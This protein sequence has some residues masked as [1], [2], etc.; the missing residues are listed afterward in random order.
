MLRMAVGHAKCLDADCAARGAV[1]ACRE[2]LGG[3]KPVGL[4]LFTGVAYDHRTI[5]AVIETVFPGVPL[6]GATTSAVVTDGGGVSEDS[7]LLVAFAGE[8]IAA[9][10]GLVRD[11]SAPGTDPRQQTRAAFEHVRNALPGAVKLC[12]A[13]PDGGRGGAQEFGQ[14]LAAAVGPEGLVLGGLAARQVDDRRPVRQFHGREIY[15]HAA[16]FLLLTGDIPLVFR[17]SR[18]WRPVGGLSRITGVDG[19]VVHRIGEGSALDFYRH[20]LGPHAEPALELPLAIACEKHK[21][22]ILRAPGFYSEEDGSIQFP[23]GV[24]EGAMVQLAEA[25]RPEMLTDI[26]QMAKT[27]AR[28]ATANFTPAGALFFSC[29]TRKDIL[30]TKAG[31][32]AGQ[33]AAALPPGTPVA[34]LY[35][36]GEL[37]AAAPGLPVH[38]QNGSLVAL[39]LGGEKPLARLTP[40]DVPS[41]PTGERE[42]LE[43][44]IRSLSRALSRAN[45]SRQRLEAQKDRSQSLMRVVNREINEAR[46]EI[47]RKNELLRQALA[48]AEEVQRNLLPQ[49]APGLPGFDIA[50]TSLYSDETG[51]DYFDFIHEP[52]EE[53]NRFGVIIGDVTGHGIAAALLMTTAR[54]FLRMRS[55]QPGSLAAVI[56][57]VNKLLCA[58][59]ADSGRFMT[60]FYLAIDIEKKRIHWVRAGHD[61]IILYDAETGLVQD[62]PDKG[63]PPLGIITEAR[64]AENSAEAMKPGQVALLATDGLWEARNAAGEMFGKERVREL[65]GRHHSESAQQ[66]VDAVLAGL[67]DYLGNSQPED[68]VTLVAI[69]VLPE[70]ASK[71]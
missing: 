61:P 40:V 13:F 9:V 6:V 34:G 56:D 24:P 71:A 17:L 35:C 15:L 65:L 64:Y 29:A 26:R 2:Q 69:K 28:E 46:L 43:R 1:A 57:D 51:G 63:G 58:D 10:T 23:A 44:E 19:A 45:A 55:F 68:D 47:Q 39:V 14:E 22:F 12:L 7:V 38:L 53:K 31:D 3:A 48:L 36:F 33:L 30:G 41:C 49:A 18:G 11:F 52:N 21:D 42:G 37:G 32:E 20:Y 70:T 54:A 59:L 62:I 16:P 5:L 66:I 50:G 27:L 25:D 8:G 67:R 4:L 60:L